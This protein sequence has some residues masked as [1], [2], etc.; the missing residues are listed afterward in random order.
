MIFCVIA[1][2]NS[3]ATSPANGPITGSSNSGETIQEIIDYLN[4]LGLSDEA[5]NIQEYLEDG[6]FVVDNT[7]PAGERFMVFGFT[8]YFGPIR[9][10]DI[11]LPEEEEDWDFGPPPT[12]RIYNLMLTLLHE[13]FHAEQQSFLERIFWGVAVWIHDGIFETEDGEAWN[14]IETEAYIYEISLLDKIIDKEIER[15]INMHVPPATDISNDQRECYQNV[16]ELISEKLRIVT[17]YNSS[18]APNIPTDKLDEAIQEINNLIDDL[19]SATPIDAAVDALGIIDTLNEFET[20][21]N[22]IN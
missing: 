6:E 9:I 12:G 3:Y 18:F 13:K 16:D 17:L 21:M 5:N 2:P 22:A 11:T 15:C 10:N 8:P 19:D 20:E 7:L 4:E 1:I 14:P